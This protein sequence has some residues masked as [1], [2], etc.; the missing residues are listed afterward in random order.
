[1]DIK[2]VPA[3]FN[4]DIPFNAEDYVHRIGR[5]GRAGAL[6]HAISFVSGSDQRL[7]A[8]IEKLLKTKI[9]LENV[10]VEQDRSRERREPRNDSRSDSRND[11]RNDSR[12]PRAEFSREPRGE[13][14]EFSSRPREG[15]AS[16]DARPREQDSRRSREVGY[17][18]VPRV[19]NDPFFDK[20]YEASVRSAEVAVAAAPD[21]LRKSAN[22]KPRRVMAALFKSTT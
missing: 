3:V 21:P 9:T 11:S 15:Y 20:P 7:V 8:D 19:K 5:T 22:I 1:L 17:M 13:R 16:R 4:F 14:S 6:G 10:T 2:D 12:E 18:P